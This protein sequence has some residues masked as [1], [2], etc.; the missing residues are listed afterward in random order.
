MNYRYTGTVL[1]NRYGP[2]RGPIWLDEVRC[3]GN[4]T[5]I[6]N[7]S[8]RGWGVHDCDH[9]EDVSVSCNASGDC[10]IINVLQI[11]LVV[12]AYSCLNILANAFALVLA[13]ALFG[14]VVKISLDT[15]KQL[16]FYHAKQLC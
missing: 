12:I 15:I 13:G 3:V 10:P 1:G 4:E 8:H 7:C 11:K 5:S 2:G 9:D 6:A 16:G 14:V